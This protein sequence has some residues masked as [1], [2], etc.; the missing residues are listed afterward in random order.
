MFV[1]QYV[2]FDVSI[3]NKVFIHPFPSFLFS[4]DGNLRVMVIRLNGEL[5]YNLSGPFEKFVVYKRGEEREVRLNEKISLSC[6]SQ[7]PRDGDFWCRN[8]LRKH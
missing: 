2:S 4:V 7:V 8:L 1:C 5:K 3:S 6:G